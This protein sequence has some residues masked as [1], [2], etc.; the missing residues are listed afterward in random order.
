M[1]EI[2]KEFAMEKVYSPQQIEDKLY[3]MWE[4]SGAF[5]AKREEGKKP[6]TIVM[7]PPNIT[8]QLLGFLRGDGPKSL[9]VNE[10]EISFCF[11]LLTKA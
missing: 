7:P 2:Q 6:F 10:L 1:S 4:D 3:K 8:G 11:G 9:S 5:I